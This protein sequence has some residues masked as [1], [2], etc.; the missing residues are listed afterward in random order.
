M[1]ISQVVKE[2]R[3]EQGLTQEQLAEKIFVSKKTISNWENGRTTPDI[4]SLI[5]LAH[6]FE[7][8]LDSL[9]LEGSTI[10]KE[11]KQR[12]QLAELTQIYWLGPMITEI[13][14]LIL[15]YFP[16][17]AS[18]NQWMLG[19]I[20]LATITN[21]LSVL[22]FKVKIYRLKGIEEKLNRELKYMR[23]SGLV[24]LGIV[25]LFLLIIYGFYN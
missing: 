16:S 12:E 15:L 22:Y 21:L 17:G 5:Q 11:L 14:L 18:G 10:V 7:L 25:L 19:I 20:V 9:L 6:L 23:I 4:E 24:L 1:E 8:S 13:L 3:K 2:K